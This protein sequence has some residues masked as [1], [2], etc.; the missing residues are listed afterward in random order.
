MGG[1]GGG[2]LGELGELV[3]FER[4]APCSTGC[5]VRGME[6]TACLGKDTADAVCV[7]I[8]DVPNAGAVGEDGCVVECAAG[9]AD[10][11]QVPGA[12][13]FD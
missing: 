4:C 5:A 10:V 9:D 12:E 3:G 6:R 13:T 11:R 7:C 1:G 2:E 8:A